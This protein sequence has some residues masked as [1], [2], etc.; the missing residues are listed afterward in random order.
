MNVP[1]ASAEWWRPR[2]PPD[3][4]TV[5]EG[6]SGG[7]SRLAFLALLAFTVVLILAP[8][9]H[10]RFLQ[11][12]HLAF[13]TAVLAGAAYLYQRIV[14]GGRSAVPLAR[15]Q[16]IAALLAAWAIVTVP[17]SMWPGGSAGVLTGVFL[18]AIVVFWLLGRVVVT[19][20]RLKVVAWTLTWIAVPL[21]VSA[22]SAFLS[23]GPGDVRLEEGLARIAGYRSALAANPNDLAL[24]LTLILPL[25]LALVG[26]TRSLAA[27][28]VLLG[29]AA[30]DIV[31][32]IATYSRGGFLVLATVVG[33]YLVALW[34]RGKKAT[35]VFVTAGIVAL[36]PL[37]PVGYVQRLATITDIHADRTGSA[38]V[39]WRDM[40]DAAAY[41][42][43]HPVFGAGIGMNLLALNEM[44]GET[45]T[46]VHN[47]YL[48]YAVD[49]GLPGLLLFVL[50][51]GGAI[52]SCMRASRVTARK[53]GYADFPFLAEGVGV[54][55]TGFA[56]AAVFYPDA[57]QFYFFY[58]AGLA[59]AVK[60]IASS[61]GRACGG[62]DEVICDGGQ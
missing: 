46:K 60:A 29:L 7:G 48:Q 44:R 47:V 6:R 19:T 21:S 62:N 49:L 20:E 43:A 61:A 37:A 13:A 3:L 23:T 18:K 40:Q 25:T 11:P 14:H 54:S 58:F 42:A 39:R 51:L 12:L 38:Q 56:V 50:L 8:Q 57:Y 5:P 33:A 16:V 1:A 27:R 17:A 34:R 9:D 31:A 22:V 53:P 36:A 41:A 4:V 15:E 30:L 32:V 55:L 45:W 35:A 2:T 10:F 24:M 52:G 28:F 59:V 26:C